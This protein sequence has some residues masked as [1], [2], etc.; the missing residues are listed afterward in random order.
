[1]NKKRFVKDHSYLV[2]YD[3]YCILDKVKHKH[4]YLD[5]VC[6]ELNEQQE[7]I[8]D[9]ASQLQGLC[10]DFERVVTENSVLRKE[11]EKLKRRL[12]LYE[13]DE[14]EVDHY[15]RTHPMPTTASNRTIIPLN[16]R[17]KRY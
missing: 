8:K 3:K 11:N 2:N 7:M 12:S 15:L 5:E 1:M 6:E 16:M 4:L 17:H 9:F 10:D 14:D 13:M